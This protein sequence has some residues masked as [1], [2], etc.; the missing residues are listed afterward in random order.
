MLKSYISILPK[1]LE[2]FVMNQLQNTSSIELCLMIHILWMILETG[3]F[4][5]K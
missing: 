2:R 4:K 3:I 5:G 1:E